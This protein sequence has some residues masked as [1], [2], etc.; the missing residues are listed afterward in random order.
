MVGVAVLWKALIYVVGVIVVVNDSDISNRIDIILQNWDG[1]ILYDI[2]SVI[3]IIVIYAEHICLQN[4]IIL[5][6]VRAHDSLTI[7]NVI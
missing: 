6:S 1:N 3:H 5:I 7:L 4:R 2:L